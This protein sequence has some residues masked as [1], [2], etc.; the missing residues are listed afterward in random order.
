LLGMSKK[1]RSSPPGSVREQFLSTY[2]FRTRLKNLGFLDWAVITM[3]IIGF[4]IAIYLQ[5]LRHP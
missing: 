1:A 3:G 4:A 5:T 2:G